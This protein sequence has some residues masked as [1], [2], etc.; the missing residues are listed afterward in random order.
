MAGY[1]SQLIATKPYAPIGSALQNIILM[2]Y[3]PREVIILDDADKLVL[4]HEY[5]V[6]PGCGGPY[7]GNPNWS[8]KIIE[9]VQQL[10]VK[11]KIPRQIYFKGLRNE[12]RIICQSVAELIKLLRA[13]D[14]TCRYI[15][16]DFEQYRLQMEVK[17]S[18]ADLEKIRVL[19]SRPTQP[20]ILKNI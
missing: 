8:T 14:I 12:F 3:F 5:Q 16:P 11:N 2:R 4:H 17:H 15:P 20:V 13:A 19:S 10:L 9:L 1:F 6:F 18:I 7:N